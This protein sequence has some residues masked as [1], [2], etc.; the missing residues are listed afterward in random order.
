MEGGKRVGRGV[1]SGNYFF[2]FRR[3]YGAALPRGSRKRNLAERGGVAESLNTSARQCLIG[4][5]ARQ[6]ALG[7]ARY[8]QLM[9]WL[10]LRFHFDSTA[11]RLGPVT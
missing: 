1:F 3:Q 2:K 10:Q 6:L 5:I 8:C 9:R 11:V 7:S 4:Q